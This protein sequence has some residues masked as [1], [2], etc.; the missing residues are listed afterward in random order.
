MDTDAIETLNVIFLIKLKTMKIKKINRF[1]MDADAFKTLN[2]NIEDM[3]MELCS[4]TVECTGVQLCLLPNSCTG[5][6]LCVCVCCTH[7]PA[8]I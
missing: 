4:S 1:G 5:N 6:T 7:T 2:V 3:E 8:H